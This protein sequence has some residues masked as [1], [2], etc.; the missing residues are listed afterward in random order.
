MVF[1]SPCVADEWNGGSGG[2][3][4]DFFLGF[5]NFLDVGFYFEFGFC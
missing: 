5:L 1:A 2:R 4:G 3:I